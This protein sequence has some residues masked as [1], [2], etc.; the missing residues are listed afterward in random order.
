[1]SVTSSPDAVAIGEGTWVLQV[2]LPIASPPYTLCYVIEDAEGAVH[3]IDPGWDLPSNRELVSSSLAS[4]G[5]AVDRVVTV[6]ATHLHADHLGL[7]GW[8]RERSG[9]SVL[10]HPLE[11]AS[12]DE[13]ARGGEQI[14]NLDEWGVPADRHSELLG[15]VTGHV[16]P[17]FTADALVGDGDLLPFSGRTL[18]VI[19]TPGHTSG[20][21]TIHDEQLDLLFTG[22]TLLP[23]IFAGLGLGG[24]SRDPIG[25]YLASLDRLRELGEPEVLP[26]HGAPFSGLAARID[27][28]RNHQ[29]LRTAE[30]ERISL[31]EPQSTVWDV[32]SQVTWTDG[33]AALDGIR[34]ASALSQTAMRMR[35]SGSRQH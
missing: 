30:V 19:H 2:P 22:D 34:L 23:S 12:L 21:I 18:R 26:G 9:A 24:A 15:A 28:A 29:L 7:A 4:V 13:L 31:A 8:I 6:T 17:R 3:L 25:D 16:Y 14:P 35:Y 1:M 10:L 11:Q 5:L 33:W 27:E 20:S 32:A